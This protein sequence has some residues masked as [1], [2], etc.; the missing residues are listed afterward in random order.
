MGIELDPAAGLGIGC[1]TSESWNRNLGETPRR[2]PMPSIS[3]PASSHR[4]ERLAPLVQARWHRKDLLHILRVL[5]LLCWLEGFA[6]AQVTTAT[7][8]GTARDES[9][10]V[11]V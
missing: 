10:A 2:C 4:S 7:V 3:C 8:S 11:L 1:C 9:G 6:V 5:A